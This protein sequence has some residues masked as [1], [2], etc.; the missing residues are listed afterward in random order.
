MKRCSK[1]GEEK[2]LS[3]FRAA[4]PCGRA[5]ATICKGCVQVRQNKRLRDRR[6]S[7]AQF[8]ASINARKRAAFAETQTDPSKRADRLVRKRLWAEKNPEK[9]KAI[10]RRNNAKS[11]KRKA[12]WR[13]EAYHTDHV[14]AATKRAKTTLAASMGLPERLLPKDLVEAKAMQLLVRREAA[15]LQIA[16]EESENCRV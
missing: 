4:R 12:A 10:A 2:D 13:R 1:C 7:D 11:L 14:F 3:A 16:A 9:I 6:Q 5:A 8:R 15:N